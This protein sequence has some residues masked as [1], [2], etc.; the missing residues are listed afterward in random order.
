MTPAAELLRIHYNFG[1]LPFSKLQQM[2]KQGVIPH[3]LSICVLSVC[4][5]CQYAKA[6]KRKWRSRTVKDRGIQQKPTEPGQV[7]SV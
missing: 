5:A 2:A 4:A 3:Q 1:H 7:T 6:T